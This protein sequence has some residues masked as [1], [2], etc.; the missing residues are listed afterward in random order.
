[1]RSTKIRLIENGEAMHI[2]N[3]TLASEMVINYN[4]AKAKR[5]LINLW[6]A[7]D[8]PHDVLAKFLKNLT[9]EI[10]K[11]PGIIKSVAHYMSLDPEKGVLLEVRTQYMND[12]KAITHIHNHFNVDYLLL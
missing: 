5:N 12:W 3:S 4:D 9:T 2:P 8:T 1:M 6:L 7:G 11:H 10:E